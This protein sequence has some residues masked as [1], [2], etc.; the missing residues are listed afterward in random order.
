MACPKQGDLRSAIAT[1]LI[2]DDA[3]SVEYYAVT[4]CRS[5]ICQIQISAVHAATTKVRIRVRLAGVTMIKFDDLDYENGEVICVQLKQFQSAQLQ[6]E[7]GDLTGT[8]IVSDQPISVM[9]GGKFTKFIKRFNEDG[10]LEQL[11]PV[12]TW[13]R[14][15]YAVQTPKSLGGAVS[16]IV[17][18]LTQSQGHSMPVIVTSL[19]QSLGGTITVIVTNLTQSEGGIIPIIVTNSTAT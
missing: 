6:V 14:T 13:G 10:L 11:P 1:R 2:P 17:T 15:H 5:G 9:S 7:K 3:L 19:T 12:R 4:V 8:H 16:V 18:N